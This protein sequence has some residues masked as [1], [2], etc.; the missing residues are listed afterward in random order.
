MNTENTICSFLIFLIFWLFGDTTLS[1]VEK[2][3]L[4]SKAKTKESATLA[5][6]EIDFDNTQLPRSDT[7]KKIA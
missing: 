3:G 2:A 6:N 1:I 4:N 7:K 5:P